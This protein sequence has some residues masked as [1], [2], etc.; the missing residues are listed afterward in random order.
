MQRQ[1][2]GL[3]VAAL[4]PDVTGTLRSANSTHVLI[5]LRYPLSKHLLSARPRPLRVLE[6]TAVTWP[7]PCP[8]RA[9]VRAHK[10]GSRSP[11]RGTSRLVKSWVQTCESA[12]RPSARR[13]AG[14]PL[15]VAFRGGSCCV[16][17][18]RSSPSPE[19]P[20]SCGWWWTRH[21]A[22]GLSCPTWSHHVTNHL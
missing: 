22:P 18:P 7:V 3:L 11:K 9:P 8:P 10:G 17:G 6:G 16:V 13:R 12:P 21:C 15:R 14:V 5:R 1:D 2:S 19:D 4:R 20:V